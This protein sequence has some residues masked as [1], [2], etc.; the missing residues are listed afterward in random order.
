MAQCDPTMDAPGNLWP[1]QATGHR[2]PAVRWR[3]HHRPIAR[4]H[5]SKASE[6]ALSMTGSQGELSVR[7]RTGTTI[8]F[9]LDCSQVRAMSVSS[10]I[11][12]RCAASQRN[13]KTNFCSHSSSRFTRRKNRSA[14]RPRSAKGHGFVREALDCTEK[15]YFVSMTADCLKTARNS[16]RCFD[17]F[18]TQGRLL[19]WQ[20]SFSPSWS[21]HHE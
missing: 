16:P 2:L 13:R 18:S 15:T 21:Q 11:S 7:P 5:G 6:P 3:P 12:A 20:T 14:S 9:D 1:E 4:S 17:F 10:F 19:L 8:S